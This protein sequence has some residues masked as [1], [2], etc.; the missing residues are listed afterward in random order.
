MV[1]P[2]CSSTK[3]TGEWTPSERLCA[4][5][6]LA[7]SRLG[8]TLRATCATPRQRDKTAWGAGGEGFAYKYRSI[9]HSIGIAVHTMMRLQ[10]LLAVILTISYVRN[11]GEKTY[12]FL[13]WVLF[14]YWGQV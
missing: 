2:S 13:L 8:H 11:S 4:K 5:T 3:D 10:K 14:T 12:E 6:L 7:H 9:A 1:L